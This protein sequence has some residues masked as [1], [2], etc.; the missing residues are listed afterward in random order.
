MSVTYF[1]WTRETKE[2]NKCINVCVYECVFTGKTEDD[3]RQREM[4]IKLIRQN[5]NIIINTFR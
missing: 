5:T 3:G 2:V 4:E 1:Q